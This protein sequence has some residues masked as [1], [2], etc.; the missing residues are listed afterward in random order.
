MK[1]MSRNLA[2]LFTGKILFLVFACVLCLLPV[3]TAFCEETSLASEEAA[4]FA[5]KTPPPL[6]ENIN[7]MADLVVAAANGELTM[8]DLQAPI[9]VPEN[10]IETKDIE[11]GNVDGRKLQLDLYQ[12]REHSGP[13]PAVIFIHGGG[14]SGGDRSDYQVYTIAFAQKGYVAATIGYRLAQPL[15]H[16]LV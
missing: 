1:N 9:A 8:I 6:P 2:A 16:V 13:L 14:W 7:E 5:L 12:P 3:S 15:R 4:L 10:V 11:Y